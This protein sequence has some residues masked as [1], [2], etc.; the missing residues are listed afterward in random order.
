MRLAPPPS[1]PRK[2]R[3]GWSKLLP[4]WR[5]VA[6]LGSSTQVIVASRAF[7]PRQWEPPRCA[8]NERPKETGE[9]TRTRRT[10]SG[11][12][13][14]RFSRRS[15]PP[16][17]PAARVAAALG[18]RCP[19]TRREWGGPEVLPAPVHTSGAARGWGAPCLVPPVSRSTRCLMWRL[20]GCGRGISDHWC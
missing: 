20:G 4:E 15:S 11:H 9:I 10:S 1:F 2:P 14:D 5:S 18:E 8:R 16:R 19:R 12:G 6:P 7:P 3:S 17:I 13:A